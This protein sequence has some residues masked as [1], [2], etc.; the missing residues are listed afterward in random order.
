LIYWSDFDAIQFDS[1]L[2]HRGMRKSW[3]LKVVLF[4]GILG[5][6]WN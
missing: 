6:L 1:N 5:I 2:C 3:F 4:L